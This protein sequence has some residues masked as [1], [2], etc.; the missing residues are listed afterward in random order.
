M[1]LDKKPTEDNTTF[2]AKLC[3]C[4]CGRQA[5]KIIIIIMNIIIST[6][7]ERH[8][9]TSR[10]ATTVFHH[11]SLKGFIDRVCGRLVDRFLFCVWVV[12]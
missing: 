11:H 5:G 2:L 3:V 10:L 4:V 7:S 1:E 6:V 9:D 8:K 12:G